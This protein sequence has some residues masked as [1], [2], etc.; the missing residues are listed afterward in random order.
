M[1]PVTVP[2]KFGPGKSTGNSTIKIWYWYRKIP[3][4]FGT[5]T[6]EFPGIFHFLGSTGK[7]WSRKKYWQRKNLVP[8]KSTG[9]G[10]R[11]NWFRKKV[12]VPAKLWVPPHSDK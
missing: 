3:L 11:K 4:E 12:P 2:E 9:T 10:T 8:E 7:N 1:V 6:G 5:G